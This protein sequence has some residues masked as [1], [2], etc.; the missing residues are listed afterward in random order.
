MIFKSAEISEC[1]KFRYTLIRKWNKSKSM[2][3]WCMLNPSTANAEQD[4]PTVRKCIGF[5]KRLGYDGVRIVNLFALR[6]TNP[7]ELLGVSDPNGP[8][9]DEILS[10]LGLHRSVIVGW[11]ASIGRLHIQTPATWLMDVGRRQMALHPC[12]CWHC[13]GFTKSGEPRHPLMLPYSTPLLAWPRANLV[14]KARE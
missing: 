9:N 13:L 8:R 14:K 7:R 12:D 5:A 10:E 2:L 11:G 6:A 4:D 1:G 3:N